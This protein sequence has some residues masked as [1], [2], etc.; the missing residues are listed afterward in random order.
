MRLRSTQGQAT[1]ITVVFLA[2]L[3]GM[4]ALVL[5]VGSW[6]RAKRAA[7]ATADA[8]ALAGAQA[9]P[10][11][12]NATSLAQTYAGKNGGLGTGG[13]NFSC[14]PTS[15]I[16][17][18][19]TITVTV[20]RTAPGFFSKLFGLRSVNV[21]ATAT[22]R[23]EPVSQAR[24]VAPITVHYTHPLLNCTGGGNNIRCNPT[25]GVQTTLD[26]EDLHAPGTG[27]GAGAFGLINLDQSSGG[28]IGANIL[29]DWLTNGYPNYLGLG[30]YNSAPSANFNN[31][32]FIAALQSVI[33]KQ[34]LFPVYRVIKGPGSNALYDIIGWVGFVPTSFNPSGSNGTI[35]GSF[36]SYIADGVQVTSCGCADLGVHKVELVN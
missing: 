16:T 33:G 17:T 14:Q 6:Y 8:A 5:D 10:N 26:L 1:V 27:N 9:L 30:Q 15:C 7:Q 32:Q 34:V 3:I 29:A 13:V 24:Y 4:A 22:A 25:F 28:N 31:S 12:G 36:T 19:D 18:N 20:H 2:V 23:S 35:T 21:G 11:T